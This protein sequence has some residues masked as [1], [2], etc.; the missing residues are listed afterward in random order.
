MVVCSHFEKGNQFNVGY[1][2][3]KIFITIHKK[4][5]SKAK[6][7]A[8]I[9]KSIML[10]LSQNDVLH[11]LECIKE[12]DRMLKEENMKSFLNEFEKRG[13]NVWD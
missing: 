13:K 7:I 11:L 6:S 3:G 9:N 8:D 5:L 10:N 2:D 4:S 1:A 12:L